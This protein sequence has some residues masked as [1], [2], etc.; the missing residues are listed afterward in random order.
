ME[1]VSRLGRWIPVA[2]VA[3]LV[4]AAMLA[5]LYANPVID[6]APPPVPTANPR[7]QNLPA[8]SQHGVPTTSVDA[9]P[10][11]ITF[12][13]WLRNA[14]NALCAIAVLL[15]LGAVLWS[16]LQR[17]ASRTRAPA[18]T[19]PEEQRRRAQESVRAAVDEGLTDLDD[20]DLDPRRA[21]IACWVRL[22]AAAAAAGT[23]R[24]PGDTSTELVG[25]LLEDHAI[26]A[27]VLAGFAAVYREAR[28]ATHVVDEAM[29]HQARSAL[30]QIRDELV[31]GADA[32]SG[33]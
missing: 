8:Q 3:V 22:E 14:F 2:M 29:R 32:G 5:A 31:H 9:Q 30:R 25:R 11:D 13:P 28:F 23:R 26:T 24:E 20:A 19:D 16:I 18:V 27:P 1:R 12:P 4:G 17:L 21:V 6:Y 33:S 7:P 10:Q 15:L